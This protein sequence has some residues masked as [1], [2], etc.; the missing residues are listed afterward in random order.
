MLG[1]LPALTALRDRDLAAYHGVEHK[2]IGAY[3]RGSRRSRRRAPKEH[4]RCGS[5]LIAPLL[6]CLV[7]G[8]V[9]VERLVDEP[10]PARP[11]RRRRRRASRARSSCSPTPSA[12]PTPPWP[13][14]CTRSGHEIQR[15]LSTREPTPE[16]LEVGTAALAAVLREESAALQSEAPACRYRLGQTRTS[17]GDACAMTIGIF[18]LT[19]DQFVQ[20][21]LIP[22][23]PIVLILVV[24]YFMWRTLRLMPRTKPQEIK[25]RSKAAVA[26]DEV[27]GIDETKD[28]LREVVEF[29][30]DPKRFKR[31][32]AKVPKGILLHG[33]AR[34]R[35][36]PAREGRRA[37]VRRQLLQPVRLVVHRDVRRA[38]RGADQAAVQ[39][40]SGERAGDRLHRRARRGGRPAGPRH[41][42]RAR[43]DAE[44]A[45]G[46]DGRLR[47]PRR[48][49]RHG[50]LEPAREA[51]QGPAAAGPLRPPGLRPGP[52]HAGS[53]AHPRG[54]HQ[55]QAPRPG[56][57]PGA[58]RAPR[59]RPHRRRPREP[60]QRGGDPGR[61]PAPRLHH[62]ARLRQRV[63][64]RGRRAADPQ[65]DHRGGEAGG[66]LA[67]GRARARLRA[68]AHRRQGARRSRSC[69]AARRS[70]TRSTSPRRTAT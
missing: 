12:T 1:M 16:Q 60:R 26:W 41:L 59:G 44:P 28:E 33:P 48:R 2:A 49:R 6:A 21:V 47:R 52:R 10:G 38:G 36:D 31:L 27:A 69:R 17:A 13:G 35:Q 55:R 58:G 34:H 7:A 61:A 51:R 39:G 3:E 65:G 25:A 9:I 64:A 18:G 5:N 54:P 62:P 19:Y 57:R 29:L 4:E 42:R 22:W 40:G 66:R 53:P 20:D 14:P 37:R 8:Q 70:A 15:L 24:A 32:G 63:R 50:R 45:A 46:R 43:P 11:R 30:S 56:R 67:R 23:A 68:A